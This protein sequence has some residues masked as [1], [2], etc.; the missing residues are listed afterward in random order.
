[1][2][3]SLS[4]FSGK[5]HHIM[6]YGFSADYVKYIFYEDGTVRLPAFVGGWYSDQDQLQSCSVHTLLNGKW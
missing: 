1:M 5:T 6:M 2:K 3:Y 4:D